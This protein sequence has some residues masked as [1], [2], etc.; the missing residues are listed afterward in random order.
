MADCVEKS[1]CIFWESRCHTMKNNQGFQI[2][3]FFFLKIRLPSV[4]ATE[5]W[6]FAKVSLHSRRHNDLISK[7]RFIHESQL[8][9]FGAIISCFPS[10]WDLL[11]TCITHTKTTQRLRNRLS[12]TQFQ[13]FESFSL[14]R[15]CPSSS[16]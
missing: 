12:I 16:S 9:L 5:T 6:H 11:I 15:L 8:L 2:F 10:M 13:T 3:F 1:Y 7:S 4:G 14:H